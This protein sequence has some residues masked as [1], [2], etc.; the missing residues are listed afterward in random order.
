MIKTVPLL[1]L[2]QLAT[3]VQTTID[4]N[5]GTENAN[6]SAT[7]GMDWL[8]QWSA[9]YAP[10]LT[11]QFNPIA[12]GIR[13][14]RTDCPWNPSHGKDAYVQQLPNGAISAGCHHASCAG[15]D[16][17]DYRAAKEP[18]YQQGQGGFTNTVINTAIKNNLGNH[19]WAKPIP[20]TLH[21]KAE[22]PMMDKAL[23]HASLLA[24]CEDVAYRKQAPIEY[25]I[26]ALLMTVSCLL[27]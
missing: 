4:I 2:Q 27:A 8:N 19:Q 13:L 7:N 17:H 22:T 25:V 5:N 3:Q 21:L 24:Y 18:G 12:N 14:A 16:W 20:L 1:L 11:G 26:T 9:H 23:I 10:E 6:I 15:K